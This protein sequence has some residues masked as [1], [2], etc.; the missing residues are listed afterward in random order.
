MEDK[1]KMTNCDY[2]RDS[3]DYWRKRIDENWDKPYRGMYF[4][5]KEKIDAMDARNFTVLESHLN[6]FSSPRVLEVACGE[7]RYVEFF[8]TLAAKREMPVDYVGV[9]YVERSIEEAKKMYGRSPS[10]GLY[11]AFFSMDMRDVREAFAEGSFDAV[12]MVAAVTSIEKDFISILEMLSSMLRDDRSRLFVFEQ[13]WHM[14]Y[15]KE[16]LLR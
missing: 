6:Q 7:G 5:P 1:L 10:P 15:L 3:R 2:T 16:T 14:E 12:F 11:S 8:K 4:D 9:D 13:Q